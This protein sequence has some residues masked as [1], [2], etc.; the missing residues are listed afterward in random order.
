MLVDLH[1]APDFAA[2][3]DGLDFVVVVAGELR[4]LGAR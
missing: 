2:A 4:G 3:V 1:I